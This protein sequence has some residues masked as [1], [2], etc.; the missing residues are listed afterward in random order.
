MIICRQ[1]VTYER[2]STRK[3]LITDFDPKKSLVIDCRQRKSLMIDFR[4]QKIMTGDFWQ[5]VSDGWFKTRMSLII[6]FSFN[7]LLIDFQTSI[8]FWQKTLWWSIF[9]KQKKNSWWS[10][11]D[12]KSSWWSIFYKSLMIFDKKFL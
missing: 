8:D 5:K 12:K 10:I 3:A 2:F 11:F 4:K 6:K 9:Q 7:N 1:E